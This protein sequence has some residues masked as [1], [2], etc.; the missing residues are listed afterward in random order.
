M[1][2]APEERRAFRL[3]AAAT[4][5]AATVLLGILAVY[6]VRQVLVLALIALFVAV[7]LE[8]A[9]RGLTRRSV[10]RPW[11]VTGVFLGLVLVIAGFIAAAAPAVVA[12]GELL[13][14]KLPGYITEFQ[15]R[16][17]TIEIFE[18][19][20][21]TRLAEWT[22]TLPERIGGS[23][24]GFA[25]RFFGALSSTLLVLV[26]AAYFLAD[27]PR[28][29]RGV[30][31]L[32]PLRHRDYARVATDVVVDK[33]GAYMIGNLLISLIAGV[34]SLLA[35]LALGVPYALPLALVVAIM[36][37]IPLIGATLGAIFCTAVAAF[38][39]GVWPKAVVLALFFI[40]YQQVENYWI[41]PRVLRGSVDLPSVAVLLVGILGAAVMGLMGALMAIPIAAAIRVLL[42]TEVRAARTT[43]GIP[44]PDPDAARGG[45]PS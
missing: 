9:V 13:A 1:S 45:L 29:R 34:V 43:A 4:L 42:S 14:E 2:S 31:R 28:L 37:I 40:A 12:Q 20:I 44:P 7:S 10:P 19:P 33:V 16:W 36:D 24:L 8:P 26:L 17:R 6:A 39:V 32:F 3:G 27:L 25:G 30:V 11:A 41:A 38:S 21:A 22:A 23:L 5:G 35:F 18:V 15:T